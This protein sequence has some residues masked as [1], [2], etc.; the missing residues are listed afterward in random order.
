V[1]NGFSMITRACSLARPDEPSILT[2]DSNA[3]G[4]IA[5]WNSRPM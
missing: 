4:G 5:R 2:I 1:P 3:A